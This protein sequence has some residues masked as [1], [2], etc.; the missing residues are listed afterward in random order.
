MKF[1]PSFLQLF[2]SIEEANYFHT[3][4]DNANPSRSWL[5]F[6]PKEVYNQ[7]IILQDEYSS[8]LEFRE[9]VKA[10]LVDLEGNVIFD[11]LGYGYKKY[12]EQNV[13]LLSFKILQD[14]KDQC[15]CIKLTF[16]PGFSEEVGISNQLFSNLFTCSEL[17]RERTALVTYWHLSNHYGIPYKPNLVISTTNKANVNQLDSVQQFAIRNQIRLPLY[18]LRWKTEQDSSESTY[19]T[20]TPVNINVSRV[21]RREIKNWR[22]VANDWINQRLAIV[23]D[24]DFVYI[25]TQ[26]EITRPYQYEEVDNGG[27]FSLSILESQPKYGDNFVDNYGLVNHKPTIISITYPNGPCCNPDGTP[28]IEPD[29]TN[30]ITVANT[31]QFQG[32]HKRITVVG[33]PNS[34]IKYRMSAS[35]IQGTS[36]QVQIWN[37][38]TNN[39]HNFNNTSQNFVGYFYIGPTGQVDLNI[40]CCLEDCTPGVNIAFTGKFELY[41]MDGS[42][43]SGEICNISA[44]KTCPLPI[45]PKWNILSQTGTGFKNVRVEGQ[46]N[47]VANFMVRILSEISSFRYFPKNNITLEGFLNADDVDAEDTWEFSI[48]VGPSGFSNDFDIQVEAGNFMG[49]VPPEASIYASLT[50]RNANGGLSNEVVGI[51]DINKRQ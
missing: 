14:Y 11:N 34:T 31:C 17:N 18:F 25:N 23:S 9:I 12:I 7:Y 26:R 10:Q 21:K 20:N 49:L 38:D 4:V 44:S 39:V 29:I 6:V 2:D 33:Q 16:N 48:P 3:S 42:T 46:A 50:L 40:R 30:E 28:L 1:N 36:K 24:S 41:K 15:L 5:K 22:V 32:I 51:F 13:L 35:V 27:D 47:S 43:L 45:A 37:T 8:I 19:A